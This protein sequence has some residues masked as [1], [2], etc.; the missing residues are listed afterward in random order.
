MVWFFIYKCKF[1]S[2]ICR[3]TASNEKEPALIPLTLGNNWNEPPVA[4]QSMVTRSYPAYRFALIVMFLTSPTPKAPLQPAVRWTTSSSYRWKNACRTRAIRNTK[5]KLILFNRHQLTGP[6][7]TDV[8]G[9]GVRHR[10]TDVIGWESK[11]LSV[12]S[13]YHIWQAWA[14]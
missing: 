10:L 12:P 2:N 3:K 5:C 4:G 1:T 14:A 7:P 11:G 9:E 8:H 6:P 13:L